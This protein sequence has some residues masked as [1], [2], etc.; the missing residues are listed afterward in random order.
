MTHPLCAYRYFIIDVDGVLRRSRQALPGAAELIPWIKQRGMDYRIVT[1]NA[2]PTLAQLCA[3][4]AGMDIQTDE[5]HV[6]SSATGAAWYLKRLAP[7]GGKVYVIGEEGIR[8]A[9]LADGLFT[10]DEQRA[11]F[12]L[13]AND[14]SFTF[15]KLSHA[16]TLIR[17]G[18]RFIASNTD[19]TYPMEVGVIPG[20]G[21]LVAA[22]RACTEV[23]P[24]V[25]GKPQPTLLDMAIDQ[26]HARREETICLGDRL[27]TDIAGA[28][29]AGLA[30]IMVTTGV[31]SRADA[32]TSPHKPTF[33]FDGLPA[34]MRAWDAPA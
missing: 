9:V 25:I 31:N 8:Q 12:V 3:T 32:A 1:N 33:I 6:I 18:A 15:E 34:I 23:E 28:A 14:R 29:A 17:N 16:C 7:Q 11:D 21:A 30:S 13:V 4:F 20:A 2:M 24:V 10:V 27:D 22:V 5:Q 26:M 19:G